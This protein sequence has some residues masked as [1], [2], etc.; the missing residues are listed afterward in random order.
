MSRAATGNG[1]KPLRVLY[2]AGTGDASASLR[3]L[4][5]GQ[6]NSDIGHIGYSDQLFRVCDEMGI[7]LLA[8]CWHPRAETTSLRTLRVEPRPDPFRDRLGAGYHLAHLTFAAQLLKEIRRFR[9][10]VVIVPF[11]PY[12]FLLAP[13]RM[14]GVTVIPA[15]HCVLWPEFQPRSRKWKLLSPL[16]GWSYRNGVGA[17]LSASHY[18]TEQVDQLAGGPPSPIVEFLPTF[19]REAYATPPPDRTRRPFRVMFVGR[20]EEE[21]GVLTLLEVA[22]RL[23]KA[24]RR[25]IVIDLCG[26]GSA[27]TETKAL[28]ASEGLG[29]IYVLHG[30]C[31]ADKLRALSAEA[32]VFV[33][34]T[35]TSFDE[36]FNHAIIEGILAGRPVITSRVC[37]AVDYVPEC[38]RLVSPDDP[39][40][41]FQ[42]VIDLAD[43]GALY[44]RL[45]RACARAGARFLNLELGF[46]AAAKEIFTALQAGE[47]PARHAIPLAAG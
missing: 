22:R 30:W 38:V 16:L 21:K 28:V 19:R 23:K 47:R 13:L 18:I 9:A 20:F 4:G 5:E 15:L 33:V 45:Q 11:E 43:D 34:P 41:Y 3:A 39:Q 40:E 37:P 25:D 35:T 31:L 42:A 8:L 27:F 7:E 14:A 29:D 32:H 2:L 24:G 46:G 10:N 44:D 6:F 12:A 36:G 26:D 17:V 1:S